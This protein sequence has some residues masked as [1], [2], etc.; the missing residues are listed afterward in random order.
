MRKLLLTAAIFSSDCSHDIISLT[1]FHSHCKRIKTDSNHKSKFR[2][3]ATD[4]SSVLWH[5][6]LNMSHKRFSESRFWILISSWQQMF[7]IRFSAKEDMTQ[8]SDYIKLQC[9]RYASCWKIIKQNWLIRHQQRYQQIKSLL[10]RNISVA[11]CMTPLSTSLSQCSICLICLSHLHL[12]FFISSSIKTFSE[13][14]SAISETKILDL[15]IFFRKL[16]FLF[17]QSI[18]SSLRF[19]CILHSISMLLHLWLNAWKTCLLMTQ[20]SMSRIKH[21]LKLKCLHFYMT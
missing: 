9:N 2:V 8:A 19:C 7:L 12:K 5:M 3:K 17:H 13:H 1:W 14:F 4:T 11:D 15:V 6:S 10:N 16:S 20:C 21:Y 18:T